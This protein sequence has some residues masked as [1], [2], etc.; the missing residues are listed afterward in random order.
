MR[1]LREKVGIERYGERVIQHARDDWCQ[2][3]AVDLNAGI[4]IHLNEPALA[5]AVY[6]HIDAE[7]LEIV[8]SPVGVDEGIGGADDV[9]SYLSDLRVNDIVE[10][11]FGV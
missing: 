3:S 4:G 9:G 8:D 5:L 1:V 6:H 10:A 7:N 2:H 11:F